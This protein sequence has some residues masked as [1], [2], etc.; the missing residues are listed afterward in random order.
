M[1]TYSEK[2][3]HLNRENGDIVSE[4]VRLLGRSGRCPSKTLVSEGSVTAAHPADMMQRIRH[5]V[6]M[7]N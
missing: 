5:I 4:A 1:C 3:H 6:S 2:E 7:E